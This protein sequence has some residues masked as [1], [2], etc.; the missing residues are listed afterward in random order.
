[1]HFPCKKE[2]FHEIEMHPRSTV[3]TK[4]MYTLEVQVKTET[5]LR[6]SLVLED[7]IFMIFIAFVCFRNGLVLFRLQYPI[8]FY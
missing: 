7:H 3:Q 8:D 5:K 4:V 2:L 1:M 6:K